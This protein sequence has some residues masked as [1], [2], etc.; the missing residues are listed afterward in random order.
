MKTQER[1]TA[2]WCRLPDGPA[3]EALIEARGYAQT[4]QDE[5]GAERILDGLL[6]RADILSICKV[7]QD[8]VGAGAKI[9]DEYGFEPAAR[10]YLQAISFALGAL[11]EHPFTVDDVARASAMI[12]AERTARKIIDESELI[13]AADLGDMEFPPVRWAVPGIVT[14]GLAMLSGSPKAG[15]SWMALGLLRAVAT[16]GLAL[17]RIET[18]RGRALYLSFEDHHRRLQ[19]RLERLG[20]Q[21]PADLDI[22][23][24]LPKGVS[25]LAYLDAYL[26]LKEDCRLVVVDTLGKG[27]RCDLNDYD[28]VTAILEPLQRLALERHVGILLIHHV[29]KGDREGSDVFDSS[30]GSQ[31]I[32]GA[33]DTSMVLERPRGQD[34]AVLHV[35]GRDIPD[36][37]HA[38]ALD[39]S[40]MSWSITEAPPEE[41]RTGPERRAILELLK[42][43][44]KPMKTGEIAKA[45]K[46]TPSTVSEHLSAML[47]A[48]I[49]RKVGYGTWEYARPTESPESPKVAKVPNPPKDEPPPAESPADLWD[50]VMNRE[51]VVPETFGDSVLTAE[52][53]KPKEPE[54][55][56]LEPGPIQ[57]EPKPKKERKP[58]APRKPEGPKELRKLNALFKESMASMSDDIVRHEYVNSMLQYCKALRKGSEGWMAEPIDINRP[59][60]LSGALYAT[61]FKIEETL[62][63][64]ADLGRRNEIIKGIAQFCRQES[65]AFNRG[66]AA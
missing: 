30:L 55:V 40:T 10:R 52:P 43:A 64:L 37:M 60:E 42:A 16:G 18:P 29:K 36:A 19:D 34:Q 27:I 65:I 25:L 5:P 13:S 33:M 58:R 1:E 50:S 54:A 31:G 57:E 48:G 11:P 24:K 49:V 56:P 66:G 35:V 41:I 23:T 62:L 21:F 6:S 14:E 44:S 8:W 2:P 28:K 12:L 39:S 32:F 20:A 59:T 7:S 45:V 9:L 3:S 53:E 26:T 15:K 46:R 47:D 51:E 4:V 38:L 22:L 63:N 61:K 17:G